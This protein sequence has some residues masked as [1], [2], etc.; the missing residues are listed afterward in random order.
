MTEP[1]YQ[2][3]PLR[4]EIEAFFKQLKGVIFTIIGIVTFIAICIGLYKF[5]ESDIGQQMGTYF[6]QHLFAFLSTTVIAIISYSLLIIALECKHLIYKRYRL[7]HYSSMMWSFIGFLTVQLLNIPIYIYADGLIAISII[8]LLALGT[9][10]LILSDFKKNRPP[11]VRPLTER[12]NRLRKDIIQALL[13][14]YR[15]G[16]LTIE[17][18]A[19]AFARASYLMDFYPE[20]FDIITSPHAGITIPRVFYSDILDDSGNK[21][22]VNT[23]DPRYK[24][25]FE[26]AH[27]LMR[28]KQRPESTFT[29]NLE[30]FFD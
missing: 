9:T 2:K 1:N 13:Q 5:G 21:L 3:P 29:P 17:A 26:R 25:Y 14:C 18:D 11:L 6:N 22:S 4:E 15:I 16:Q 23:K 20:S 27:Y 24:L 30:S 8:E 12:E 19:R 28:L 7:G 10:T